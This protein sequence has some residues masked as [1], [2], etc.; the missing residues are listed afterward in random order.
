MKPTEAEIDAAFREEE[1]AFK[2]WAKVRNQLDTYMLKEI[3]ARKRLAMARSAK[4]AI[5]RDVMNY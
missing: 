2:A 5:M 3:A 1:E 4:Q